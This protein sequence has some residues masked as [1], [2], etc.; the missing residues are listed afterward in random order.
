M[1]FGEPASFLH[2][3]DIVSLFAEGPVSGFI[4]TLGYYININKFII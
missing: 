1:S 4:S 3:G 2:I